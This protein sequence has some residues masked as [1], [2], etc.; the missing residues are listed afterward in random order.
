M[1]RHEHDEHFIAG[2]AKSLVDEQV[3]DRGYRTSSE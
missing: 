2:I 3:S 1:H